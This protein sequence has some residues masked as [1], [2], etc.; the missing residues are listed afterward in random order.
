MRK[1]VMTNN[2]AEAVIPGKE[3]HQGLLKLHVPLR[4]WG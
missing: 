4:E 3:G 2:S 1:N